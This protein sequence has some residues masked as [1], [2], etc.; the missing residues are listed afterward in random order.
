MTYSSPP[1][2]NNC[3][4]I[5]RT[6]AT[7]AAPSQNLRLA[8][9]VLLRRS[10]DLTLLRYYGKTH[11]SWPSSPSI[12]PQGHEAQAEVFYRLITPIRRDERRSV[13][14]FIHAATHLRKIQC[15]PPARHQQF[16]QVSRNSRIASAISAFIFSYRRS[17]AVQLIFLILRGFVVNLSIARRSRSNRPGR[18][19]RSRSGTPRH[20]DAPRRPDEAHS[21]LGPAARSGSA[22]TCRAHLRSARP[23]C[24]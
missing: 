15:A 8:I 16:Y 10:T 4:R 24:R 12:S 3:T 11:S 17:S 22:G 1:T 2:L 13:V 20:R 5:T 18:D 23:A 14:S 21:G 6:I 9:L 7:I 19:S